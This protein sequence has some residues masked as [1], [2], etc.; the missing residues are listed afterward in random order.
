MVSVY[1]DVRLHYGGIFIDNSE[2]PGVELFNWVGGNYVDVRNVC[3]ES[4]T[5]DG[6][7][8][9]FTSHC[10][11]H[12]SMNLR[13][14]YMVGS[15]RFELDKDLE[16]RFAWCMI[17]NC[18]IMSNIY[19]VSDLIVNSPSQSNTV[20]NSVSV[21]HSVSGVH[22]SQA[23]ETEGSGSP[24]ELEVSSPVKGLITSPRRSERLANMYEESPQKVNE[25]V[26]VRK[27]VAKKSVKQKQLNVNMNKLKGKED[28]NADMEFI[29]TSKIPFKAVTYYEELTCYVVVA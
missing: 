23:T 20:S 29:K 22:E 28:D 7:T 8:K 3:L 4:D 11:L 1:R 17:S 5:V 14:Y 9:L 6:L 13:F 26:Q 27:P 15:N 18:D 19:C 12:T 2:I 21:T 16:V 24:I 25:S 10:P